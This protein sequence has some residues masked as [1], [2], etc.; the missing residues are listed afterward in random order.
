M[1]FNYLKENFFFSSLEREA[2][3]LSTLTPLGPFVL[4]DLQAR[5]FRKRVHFAN[6]PIISDPADRKTVDASESVPWF[7]LLPLGDGGQR[8]TSST[9]TTPR[10]S[11]S[12]GQVYKW[13]AFPPPV[14]ALPS[15]YPAPL[16]PDIG[17]DEN[18]FRTPP[19]KFDCT[20]GLFTPCSATTP[21]TPTTP[22][23]PSRTVQGSSLARAPFDETSPS[24]RRSRVLQPTRSESVIV[25]V[26][27][28]NSV[29]PRAH[30]PEADVFTE[31]P[32]LRVGYEVQLE[33]VMDAIIAV[34]SKS[35]LTWV[36]LA[37]VW[38]EVL[39]IEPRW[40]QFEVNVAF[41]DNF[42]LR[43]KNTDDGQMC[44]YDRYGD[45]EV[46]SRFERIRNRWTARMA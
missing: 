16:F 27:S 12:T 45:P 23:T 8:D 6:L 15:S 13:P 46:F 21:A 19:R 3:L 36:P 18:L 44:N 10:Q 43:L 33:E 4:P 31:E 30:S 35:K 28:P 42:F 22:T 5:P 17:A 2:A 26:V 37:E 41:Q 9:P 25:S 38:K 40:I 11:I 29:Q 34:L 24:I 1:P 20:K 14:I 7:T 32:D 39:E